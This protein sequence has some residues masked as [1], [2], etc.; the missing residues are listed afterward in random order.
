MTVWP[1]IPKDEACRMEGVWT[2]E[3][4]RAIPKEPKTRLHPDLV[5]PRNREEAE[6]ILEQAYLDPT[7]EVLPATASLN[8]AFAFGLGGQVLGHA[9]D[10]LGY[11]Q[12]EDGG[13]V[14]VT[15]RIEEG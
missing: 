13:Y 11:K 3:D 2:I 14:R 12:V 6:Y 15:N 1:W 4:T 8:V 9:L 10:M 7:A 5:S